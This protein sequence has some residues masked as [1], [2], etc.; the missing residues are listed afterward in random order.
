MK[1]N[2]IA[3]HHITLKFYGLNKKIK[4]L[5]YYFFNEILPIPCSV[6]VINII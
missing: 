5:A 2:I 6:C 4:M 1:F 3:P